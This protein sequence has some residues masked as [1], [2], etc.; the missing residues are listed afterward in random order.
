MEPFEPSPPSD[1]WRL[2]EVHWHAYAETRPDGAQ[3]RIADRVERRERAPDAVLRTPFE[4]AKWIDEQTRAH[5]L[6]REVV[7]IQE[8]VWV[9]IGDEDDLAHLRRENFLIASRGDSIYTDIFAESDHHD[10]YVEAVTHAQCTHGCTTDQS[11]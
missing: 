6:H 9:S 3:P 1:R 7:A 5:V 11:E 4:V 8:R 2:A 10:L